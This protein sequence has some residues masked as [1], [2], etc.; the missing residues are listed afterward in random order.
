V[1]AARRTG[2]LGRLRGGAV[3][4]AA[5]TQLRPVQPARA[6]R[7]QLPR[8]RQPR[9]DELLDADR[10]DGD[11]DG[12]GW[13]PDELTTT[14]NGTVDD[15]ELEALVRAAFDRVPPPPASRYSAGAR[16][17]FGPARHGAHDN[18]VA[19]T[20]ALEAAGAFDGLT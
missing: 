5:P 9:Y 7:V 4:T 3:D 13:V 18:L 10:G 11:I 6:C 16:Y 19:E 12:S 14:L 1:R 20:T 17:S 8:D 2:L 15:D